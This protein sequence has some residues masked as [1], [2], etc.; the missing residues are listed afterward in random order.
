MFLRIMFAFGLLCLISTAQSDVCQQWTQQAEK[1]YN[2]KSQ[3]ILTELHQKIQTSSSCIARDKTYIQLN[4]SRVLYDD[5]ANRQVDGQAKV[6]GLKNILNV[7]PTFW[8][9]LVDLGDEYEENKKFKNAFE[10]Y[11][12]ALAAINDIDSTPDSFAP[13]TNVIK[14]LYA[15]INLAQLAADTFVLS[16]TRG[17]SDFT[18]KTRGTSVQKHDIPIHFDFGEGIL[19]QDD[20]RYA[21]ALY[22]S[23]ISQDSPN[24]I[25]IGHTDPTGTVDVNDQLSKQRAET[26]KQFLVKKKYTG[27]ITVIGKG[28]KAPLFSLH[29][30]PKAHYGEIK[31]HKMLRRV[32]IRKQ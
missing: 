16:S 30:D 10:Y 11:N 4:L 22:R 25:L 21:K 29:P 17:S 15:K 32:E 8:P 1:A 28:E 18:T 3:A 12:R 24:I 9:A 26:V 5:M 23:L 20:L 27:N 31:W 14:T 7:M 2:E 6:E 19:Q 13:D